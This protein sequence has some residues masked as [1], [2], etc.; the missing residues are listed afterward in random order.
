MAL[1]IGLCSL[2]V[3]CGELDAR[4]RDE[5]LIERFEM[6]RT[7]FQNAVDLMTAEPVIQRVDLRSDGS[8]SVQPTDTD[9]ARVQA[10]ADF[11]KKQG[12]NSVG[13][14]PTRPITV[15]FHMHSSGIATSGQLKTLLFSP[16]APDGP[17]VP[18][19]DVEIA[20]QQDRWRVVY[21]RVAENW[22]IGNS[23][24]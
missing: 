24:C 4:A 15:S 11:M 9:N 10:L 14:G 6:D 3:A 17:V 13:A 7:G 18:D 2:S 5:A 21:R 1:L 23:C 8:V 22:Y 16:V 20:T 19:T 12:I